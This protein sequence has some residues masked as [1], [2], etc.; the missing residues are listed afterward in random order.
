V[1]HISGDDAFTIRRPYGIRGSLTRIRAYDAAGKLLS[2]PKARDT[3]DE[4]EI[5]PVAGAVRYVLE[6]SGER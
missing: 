3:G 1:I 2:A 5:E 4:A 6:F